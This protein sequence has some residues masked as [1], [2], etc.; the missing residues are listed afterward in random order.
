MVLKY[1]YI[2][3]GWVITMLF[4]CSVDQSVRVGEEPFE[5]LSEYRFFTGDLADLIPNET[6]LPYDLNSPLFSDYAHKARFVWMPAGTSAVYHEEEVLDFPEGAVLIKNFY[7]NHDD[8]QIEEGRSIIETRLLVK[9]N[10]KW[11]A[12]SY[13]WNDEQT[14]AYLEVIGDIKDVEWIDQAGEKMKVN[15]I[16]PNKNQCKGCHYNKGIQEP[17]GPKVRNLNKSF[18]YADGEMNQLD[19]WSEVGYLTGYEPDAQHPRVAIWSEPSSGSLHERAMAYLEINCGHCHNPNGPAN[20]TGLSLVHNASI[21]QTIGVFKP[22]VAAG[23]GT[24]GHQFNIV[25]GNPGE[26]ILSYRMKST[27]PGVMMPELGRRLIHE[28]GLALIEEWIKE[29]EKGVEH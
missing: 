3:F 4:G 24:G 6:V 27:D 23:R 12:H 13:I 22:S 11:E 10:A 2:A 26:S 18:A 7:Y 20:T 8:R 17:I 28:E 15:Y 14:D 19:K 25:P 1:R 29:M 9:T 21:D 5:Q 16:I